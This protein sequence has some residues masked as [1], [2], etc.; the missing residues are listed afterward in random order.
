MAPL[1]PSPNMQP[2]SQTFGFTLTH[3]TR[4]SISNRP[5]ILNTSS[6]SNISSLQSAQSL[7]SAPT[8]S[9][10]SRGL[11][12]GLPSSTRGSGMVPV[13]YA[14]HR[15]LSSSPA[16][17]IYPRPAQGQTNTHTQLHGDGPLAASQAYS[18]SPSILPPI[19]PPISSLPSLPTSARS[20]PPT[21]PTAPTAMNNGG[22]GGVG[23]SGGGISG[24]N[25]GSVSSRT[26]GENE[27]NDDIT[28]NGT[29][30]IYLTEDD[31]PSMHHHFRSKTVC[32]LSC[33]HCETGVCVRGM[34]A[35]LL[36]DIRIE[37]YST[38]VPPLSVQLVGDD[39][40]TQ[41]CHCKIR[42]VACLT[43]GNVLGYHIT[44][45]CQTCMEACN[46]GHFWMFH[47]DGVNSEER[48]D[49]DGQR[50]LLWAHLPR[51]EK[52]SEIL[53]TETDDTEFCYR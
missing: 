37:L 35:M 13:A 17:T 32:K 18:Y 9:T 21:A 34:K 39:Y 29:S 42:D 27:N 53:Q 38:D 46:N 10:T 49:A 44:Q 31:I 43:C 24:S 51:A 41:N 52:D 30:D 14:S 1:S 4:R 3:T 5:T 23:M 12:Y 28:S 33:K 2:T 25:N 50:I 20:S 15:A 48:L 40:M 45:P 22:H 6:V 11:S 26:E 47:T 8:L 36:A 16:S 7:P 19:L